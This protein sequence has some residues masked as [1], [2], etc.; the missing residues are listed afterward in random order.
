MLQVIRDKA[1]GWIAW[2]IVILISIPFALWGIQSYL[3]VGSEP[4]A[5]K[6]NGVEITARNLQ[7]EYQRFRQL[8]QMQMGDIGLPDKIND[9]QMRRKVLNTMIDKELLLQASR[10]MGLRVS[11]A[12]LR[13]VILNQ[14]EFQKD[15]QYNQQAYERQMRHIGETQLSYEH[16]LRERMLSTQLIQAVNVGT[17]ITERELDEY[18]RLQNQ[19]REVSYFVIPLDDNKA[20]KA[21]TDEE[22]STYYDNH[23]DDYIAPEQ[24]KLEYILLD[25][26]VGAEQVS[27]S[28]ELLREFYEDHL[29]L[30][31][32]PEQRRAS[33]ILISVARDADQ[34]AVDEAL[35]KLE[36]LAEQIRQ[37]ASFEA[38]AKKH[39]ED[40]VSAPEGGDLGDYLV[41]GTMED[42]PAF[43]AALFRLKQGEVSKPVRS[44]FGYHLIKL[45]EIKPGDEKPFE[46]IKTSV[47]K[48]Y[49]NEEGE[50]RYYEMVEELGKLSFDD[51]NSLNSSAEALNVSVQESDWLTR[52]AR[53]SVLANPKVLKAA[54]SDEVLQ[55]HHNSDVIELSATRSLVVRVLEHRKATLQSLEEVRDQ[56]AEHLL[57]QKAEQQTEAV[58]LEHIK[59]IKAGSSIAQQAGDYSVTGPVTVTRNDRTLPPELSTVVFQTAKPQEGEVTPGKVTLAQGDQA[60]FVLSKVVEGRRDDEKVKKDQDYLQQ[61]FSKNYYNRILADLRSR[62]DI[63]ILLKESEE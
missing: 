54:F 61:L 4:L 35:K 58:A 3:G 11:S 49:R 16:K 52:D 6:V 56:I 7:S 13:G 19:T 8:W 20:D 5:A 9:T 32:L 28:D 12:M 23:E 21:I 26:A 41:Q 29:D 22:I 55:E 2:V 48:D 24:V 34:N 25:T 15:G 57:K 18:G 53:G 14:P 50:R 59:A 43:E 1:Q 47:E 10:D 62:A 44:D 38:L 27:V 51:V 31:L 36:R 63:E 33:H 46:T 40:P 42:N 30:Y 37:G 17:F 45:T 60:V 39:S